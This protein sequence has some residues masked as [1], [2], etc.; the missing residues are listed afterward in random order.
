ME[1]VSGEGPIFIEDWA[2]FVP[3]RLQL[4]S[5]CLFAFPA[6]IFNC[7]HLPETQT[8]HQ[9]RENPVISSKIFSPNEGNLKG[10]RKA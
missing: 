3:L 1:S 5:H 6:E 7:V 2:F 4:P 8:A 9:R 10:W